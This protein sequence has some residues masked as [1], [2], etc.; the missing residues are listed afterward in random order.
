M[1]AE[2]N[3]EVETLAVAVHGALAFGHLLGLFYNVR[4]RNAFDS[5]AHGAAFIYDAWAVRKHA[6]RIG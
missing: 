6:R 4:Q 3:R 5:I 1:K 2:V